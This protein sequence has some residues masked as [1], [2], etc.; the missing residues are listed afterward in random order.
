MTFKRIIALLLV[1]VFAALPLASCGGGD[2]T[3]KP[4]QGPSVTGGNTLKAE[5]PL[6]RDLKFENEEIRIYSRARSWFAKEMT[7]EP[8]EAVN[9]IHQ[10]VYDRELYVEEALGIEITNKKETNE[11]YDAVTNTVQTLF[12]ADTDLYDVIANNGLQSSATILRGYYYD[13][14]DTAYIDTTMP[15]YN[16]DLIQSST[17]YDQ[18]YCLNGYVTLSSYQMGLVMF[19]NQMLLDRYHNGVNLYDEVDNKTWTL[20]RLNELVSGVYSDEN[21]NNQRDESGDLFGLAFNNVV[22]MW[23]FWSSCDLKTLAQDENGVPYFYVDEERALSAI[24]KLC[25]LYHDNNGALT[26]T[27]VT[28]N[29]GEF[30]TCMQNFSSDL[31]LFAHLRLLSVESEYF[32]NMES[33]YG[34]LPP[35]LL[36]SDQ[37][38]YAVGLHDQFTLLYLMGTMDESKLD[39]AGAFIELMSWYSYCYTIDAYAEVALKGRYSRDEDSRR[40]IDIIVNGVVLEPGEIWNGITGFYGA[41]FL[42]ETVKTNQPGAISRLIQAKEKMIN[43][44][45]GKVD[46]FFSAN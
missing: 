21:A 5:Y 9:A 22:C 34:I 1:V 7:V 32:T 17:V 19:Y 8:D 35:P 45:L 6:D 40:M 36:D 13:F 15:W 12:E 33:A 46:D 39:V 11:A 31:Y 23:S 43:Y 18:L 29:D 42:N 44:Y 3:T 24:E 28:G 27:H 20:D 25:T 41:H 16:Q 4:P 10:S 30:E 14:N 26:M 2:D 38:R 37:G